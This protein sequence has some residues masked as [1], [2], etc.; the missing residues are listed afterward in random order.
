MEIS[1]DKIIIKWKVLEQWV[2]HSGYY[3]F[4][5]R[6]AIRDAQASQKK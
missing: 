2:L 3:Q 4:L 1:F 5:R 6:C